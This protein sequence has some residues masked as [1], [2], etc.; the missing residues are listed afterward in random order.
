MQL[1]GK[2]IPLNALNIRNLNT[3]NIKKGETVKINDLSFY[4]KKSV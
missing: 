2:F 4:L 1:R 3:L